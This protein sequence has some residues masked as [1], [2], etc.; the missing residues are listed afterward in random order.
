[1]RPNKKQSRKNWEVL[2]SNQEPLSAL[3]TDILDLFKTCLDTVDQDD[4]EQYV[5]YDSKDV[6]KAVYDKIDKLLSF[7]VFKATP[8]PFDPAK[9]IWHYNMAGLYV[10]EQGYLVELTLEDLFAKAIESGFKPEVDTLI[11]IDESQ[12]FVSTD[13][14][15]HIISVLFREIRKFGVGLLLATQNCEAFPYGY[16]HQRGYQNGSRRRRSLCGYRWEET[17]DCKHTFYP[18]EKKC[19]SAGQQQEHICRQSVY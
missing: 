4:F 18:A 7:G 15:D 16:H 2:R 5:R 6:L 19:F 12:K 10:E 8:P 9:P 17:W 3:K 14:Q 1:M 13:D 11:F